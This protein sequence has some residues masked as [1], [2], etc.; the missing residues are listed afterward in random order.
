MKLPV[1]IEL[2]RNLF[3]SASSI[4]RRVRKLDGVVLLEIIAIDD[5]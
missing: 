2:Q 4:A 1:G 3:F 5:P